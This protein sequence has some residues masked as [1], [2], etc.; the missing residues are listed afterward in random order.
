MRIDEL[1]ESYK[2]F[3]PLYPVL[4]DKDGKTI[5]GKHRR[6]VDSNWPAVKLNI[7]G[8]IKREIIAL[9]ANVNRREISGT[10]IS[11][12]LGKIADL[13][14]WAPRKI[15]REI[16]R[17]YEWVLKY[18]PQRYK[19]KTQAKKRKRA[20]DR[21]SDEPSQSN[22]SENPQNELFV[23]NVWENG[24]QRPDYGDG[25][26]HGNTPPN[27]IKQC[28][29]KYASKNDVILDPMAGSGTTIDLC[30][31]LEY[32]IKAFDIKPLRDDIEFGD[33]EKSSLRNSSIDFIF[34]H[35]PY[36]KKVVYSDNPNDLSRLSFD[37]F[38]EKSENI[39][40]EMHRILKPNRFFALLIGDERH[41][42]KLKDLTSCFSL[43][44]SKYFILFDKIIYLNKNQPKRSQGR[45]E[46]T[47]MRWR[48]KKAGSHLIAADT[49]LIFKK[50]AK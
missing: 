45:I 31:E 14:G 23:F 28:L 27:L 49:L 43:I 24:E 34:A 40:K 2:K 37:R 11:K 19:D 48:A 7:E 22:S 46:Q 39:I 8:E 50:G 6:K 42:G 44:G 25:N 5:D 10:E 36:W 17:K 21:Q 4:L 41:D 35:F 16:S 9:I 47:L 1:K 20:S 32:G 26:F 13:T 18:L 38:I 33:A 15:A 30:N 12:R 3:G 29:L